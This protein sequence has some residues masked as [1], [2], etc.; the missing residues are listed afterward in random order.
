MNWKKLSEAWPDDNTCI[1]IAYHHLHEPLD[2]YLYSVNNN[3]HGPRFWWDELLWLA[4]PELPTEGTPSPWS[5][6]FPDPLSLPYT[7]ACS[8]S[9]DLVLLTLCDSHENFGSGWYFLEL[10]RYEVKESYLQIFEDANSGG[11]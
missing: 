8:E 1:V 5:K 6:A 10:P 3:L 9:Q 2:V 4:L 11:D 7:V